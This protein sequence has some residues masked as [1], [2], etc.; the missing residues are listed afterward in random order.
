MWRVREK[1]TRTPPLPIIPGLQLQR[2]N[3]VQKHFSGAR[4]ATD[5]LSV[6]GAP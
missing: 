4:L 6:E 1:A 2:R 5:R 3:Y